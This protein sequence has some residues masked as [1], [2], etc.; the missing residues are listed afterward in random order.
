LQMRYLN[1]VDLE[2]E[3]DVLRSNTSFKYLIGWLDG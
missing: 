2:R 3:K 1:E